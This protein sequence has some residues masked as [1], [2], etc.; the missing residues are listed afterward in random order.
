MLASANASYAQQPRKMLMQASFNP[1]QTDH[2]MNVVISGRVFEITNQSIPN[3]VISIQ[4]TN[5]QGTSIH[6]TIAYTDQL[7]LFRDSFVLPPSSVAGNYTAYLVADKPGYETARLTLSF[8]YF[9]PD[10]SIQA[11]TETVTVQQGQTATVSV[12]ILSLR[13]FDERVNLTAVDVPAGVAVEF[14][15]Q[16]LI[17]SAVSTGTISASNSAAVGNYSVAV[18]G[19][20]GSISHRATFLLIVSPGPRQLNY[21]ELGGAAVGILLVVVLLL[22]ARSRRKPRKH[23]GDL[24]QLLREAA[25]DTGYVATARVIARLEELRAMGKVDEA[26][27]QRLKREYEK[28]LE[29][30]K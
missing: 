22:Y 28:K 1:V 8:A 25:A 15:P 12:T 19:V 6:V 21:L 10:F 23:E 24:D 13:G 16:S 4:V 17:P 14:N 5:P 11:S 2:G 29:K 30:S 27:Y 9:T 18:L 7:G 26:T 3:A 20:S